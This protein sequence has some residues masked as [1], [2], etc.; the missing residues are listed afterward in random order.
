LYLCK[1]FARW[2]YKNTNARDDMT[3]RCFFFGW[4]RL[5]LCKI[6]ARWVYKNTNA[7]DDMTM[8]C[9][10][11]GW[12]RLYLCKILARWVYKNTN[13][14]DDMT[15]RWTNR[16]ESGEM[17]DMHRM[18]LLSFVIILQTLPIPNEDFGRPNQ[19]F[20][21]QFRSTF[22]RFVAQIEY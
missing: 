16:T 20:R 6:F 1:I 4:V 19:P 12:V 18:L 15:M 2:V 7:R 21:T 11:F 17:C 13:A 9:F 5:Y 10:F 8:R 3:M 22:Q 14:R